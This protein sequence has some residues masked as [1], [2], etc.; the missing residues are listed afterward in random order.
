MGIGAWIGWTMAT[1]LPPKPTE[2]YTR[3]IEKRA[4][5]E[6]QNPQKTDK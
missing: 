4:E 3:E 1:T 5:E 6:N 2:E